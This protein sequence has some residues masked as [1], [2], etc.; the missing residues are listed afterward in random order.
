MIL[1]KLPFNEL[2]NK[3]CCLISPE[4]FENGELSLQAACH[5]IDKWP[6]PVPGETLNL[7]L[8]GSVFQVKINLF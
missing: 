6:A 8:M 2:F 1:S 7:P 5:N 4:Y 3:I